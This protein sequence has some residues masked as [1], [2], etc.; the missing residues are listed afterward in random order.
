MKLSPSKLGLLGALYFVQG[1]PF[2]FQATALP[3]YLRTQG[4]SVTAIGFLGLLS[5]PW[6]FKALWA[7]LVDRYGSPRI[8]RRKS[9]ILPLQVA[10]AATCALAAFVPVEGALPV[11]LG[12]I[13]LMN[14][15]AATQDIAVDGL[16]VD[17]LRPEEMGLG[18]TAQVVGYKLG[19][20][21]GGGLLVWASQSIGWRG[22]FLSMAGLSLTVF[23][24]TLFAREPAPRERTSERTSWREVLARLR[25]AFLLP[26]TGWVLLF[27]ATYKLGESLSDVLFKVFLVHVGVRPEQIGL[28]VGTWGMAA[29]LLG[30]TAGGLLATRMPLLGALWLT[31]GL[32]VVPLA[33]RWWLAQW[34]VSDPSIIGVTMAE[35]FFGGALTTVMFAFMMSQVDPRIG[36]THYTLFASIEVLGKAPG[37]PI[38]GLLVG[39]AHW[40]YAQAF[41][42]GT[43]LSVAFLFLLVPLR[44][45]RQ[46][47]RSSPPQAL[48]S[49][50]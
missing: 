47:P 44:G 15:L 49:D 21:T 2:G 30:S 11:L 29:S 26:G 50:G 1:M 37:G 20:L 14:L 33:G 46:R 35:E 24:I 19:M 38:G 17:L 22:L 16:A 13:F 31:A 3:V 42:L 39:A 7:P 4:V 10:L 8:G 32:R 40:S 28:W 5:L 9:W 6:M 36:A 34:G 12:L 48:P 23:L 25:E 27:I 43:A 18:N 45:L 41:L